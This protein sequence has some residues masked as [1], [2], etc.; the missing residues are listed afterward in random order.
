MLARAV[1]GNSAFV[2]TLVGAFVLVLLHRML[3]YWSQRWHAF[4][5]L[6]K[7]HR[8]ILIRDGRLDNAVAVRNRLSNH[9]VAEDLRLHG[10]VGDVADVQLA[11]LERN[12]QISVVPKRESRADA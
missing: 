4:G 11:V 12:G 8:D 10:N 9:D 5:N 7:G 6:I 1:N 2:P 3:A